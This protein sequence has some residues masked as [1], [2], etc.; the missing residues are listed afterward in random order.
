MNI[1]DVC[2]AYFA[3]WNAHDPAG[4]TATFAPDGRYRDPGV[5]G[6]QGAAIANYVARLI[7]EFPDL[8][9]EIQSIGAMTPELVAAEW[10]MTGTHAALKKRIALPGS[11]F[12]KVKDGQIESVV[13][14]FDSQ[15]MQ[16][17]L[18]MATMSYP[19]EPQGPMS[20]GSNIRFGSDSNKVPGAISITWI[21]NRSESDNQYVSEFTQKIVEET[22]QLPGFLGIMV[23]S[24][25]ERGYTV[26]AWEKVEDTR[27]LMRGGQHKESMKWFFGSESQAIGMT[28][29]WRLDHQ[30]M[31]LRCAACGKVVDP[32]GQTGRC[33]CGEPSPEPPAFI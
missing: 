33:S 7:A 18:G 16:H 26:T 8:A 20:F 5:A 29:V 30:R 4:V 15:T 27:Q 14:Y 28:S 24:A 25:G 21:E 9:F 31:M 32:A 19:A 1:V 10:L 2:K 22:T 11:D 17:Q 6:L 23:P 3:A 12:I 13:G